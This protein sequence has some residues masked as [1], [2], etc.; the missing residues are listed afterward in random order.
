MLLILTFQI[1]VCPFMKYSRLLAPAGILGEPFYNIF[2]IFGPCGH[3]RGTLLQN[4]PKVWPLRVYQGNPFTKYSK[5]LAPAGILREPFYKIFQIVGSCGHIRG[6]LLQNIPNVWPLRAY[7]GSPFTTYSKKLAP[8]GIL[9]EPFYKIVQN[10]GPCGHIRGTLLQ[11]SQN[12][13]R[14]GRVV[15]RR[16]RRVASCRVGRRVFIFCNFYI[17]LQFVDSPFVV[18]RVLEC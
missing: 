12:S 3:I 5:L 6:T 17:F 13:C 11:N 18:N 4:I 8:A 16:S 2:Q 10:F 9:R 1:V 14:V 15:S 7:Q